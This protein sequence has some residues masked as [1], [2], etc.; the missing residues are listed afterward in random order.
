MKWKIQISNQLNT[1]IHSEENAL[2]NYQIVCSSITLN[3]F[4]IPIPRVLFFLAIITVVHPLQFLIRSQTH[5]L[6][7]CRWT[8][9]SLRLFCI[10][11]CFPPCFRPSLRIVRKLLSE[12]KFA[13]L[14]LIGLVMYSTSPSPPWK[15][16][17]IGRGSL[18]SFSL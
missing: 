18:A 4:S 2:M 15:R 1:Q 12:N 14:G 13:A 3:A 11:I 16:M 8:F 6:F 17:R 7:A 9:R 10:Y 5:S